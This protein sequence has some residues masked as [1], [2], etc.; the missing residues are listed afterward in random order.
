MEQMRYNLLF[1][2]LVRLAIEDAVWD[3]AVF[4]KNH[5]HLL[6]HEMVDLFFPE[7]MSLAGKQGLLSREHFSVDGTLIQEGASTRTSG[8]RTAWTSRRP[9]VAVRSVPTGRASGAATTCSIEHRSGRGP[10]AQRGGKAEP[11]FVIRGTS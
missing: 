3:H 9:A 4:P 2:R 5:D 10:V 6:E 1:R 8:P 7:V 11:S